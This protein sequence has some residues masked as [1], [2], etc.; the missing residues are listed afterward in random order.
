ME[1][2][3]GSELTTDDEEEG[4]ER[5]GG[6]R[7]TLL[8][9]IIVGVIGLGGGGAMGGRIL[10]PVVGEKLAQREVAGPAASNGGSHGAEAASSVH[11]VDN[12]VANPAGSEGRRFL[13]ASVAIQLNSPD[14][15]DVI[16]TRDFEFR[17]ALLLILGSKTVDELTDI[18]MRLEI[19][20][21][22][23]EGFEA[24]VG[25]DIIHQIFIPQ[26]VIQ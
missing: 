24:I 10:G 16:A 12:L 6:K 4:E 14:D 25:P 21:E 23:L 22:I 1:D 7:V 11:I 13:L 3:E 20:D 9:L 5:E 18:T 19:V 2:P 15:I 8:A 17:S 26:W